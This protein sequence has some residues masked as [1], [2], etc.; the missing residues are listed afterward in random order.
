MKIICKTGPLGNEFMDVAY[1]KTNIVLKLELYKT[2]E[3]MA[4][5]QHVKEHGATIA[6]V[7]CLVMIELAL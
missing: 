6:T 4:S 1:G 3:Q 7:L 5:K 2:R